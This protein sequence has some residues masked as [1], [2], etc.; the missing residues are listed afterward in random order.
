MPLFYPDRLQSNNPAS[1][2]IVPASEIA[3]FKSVAT[4]ASLYALADAILSESK[5]NAGNDAIGQQWYVVSK[6]KYYQLVS[7]ENRKSA[8]GWSE[9]PNSSDLSGQIEDVIDEIGQYSINGHNLSDSPIWIAGSDVSLSGYAEPSQNAGYPIASDNVNEGIGKLSRLVR[10]INSS[11]GAPDGI[12]T[13]DSAGKVPSSQLPSYVDDVIEYDTSSGFPSDGEGGKIYVDKSTNTTWRWSGTQY[14]Q[15]KGDL[16]IGTTSGTAFD[17]GV[18]TALKEDYE[19]FSNQIKNG[20]G[21]LIVSGARNPFS[22]EISND[23]GWEATYSYSNADNSGGEETLSI[24]IVNSS[25][26]GLMD[27]SM[28]ESHQDVVE[29]FNNGVIPDSIVVNSDSDSVTIELDGAGGTQNAISGNIPEATQSRAGVLSA[30]DKTLLDGIR[31]G[32]L[33]LVTPIITGTWTLYNNDDTI[34][35]SR[36]STDNL[37][38]EDGYKATFSGTYKWVSA[39]GYKN[40]T[41]V[42]S[43]SSWTD[44]PA[45]GVSSGT[46]DNSDTKVTS[47][48]TYRITIQAP[49]TGLMVDGD[50][51]VIASGNDQTSASRSITFRG[52]VYLGNVT[53]SSPT[54]SDIEALSNSLR[55]KGTW[56]VTKVITSP[57]QYYVIAYP[58]SYGDISTIIQD[59]ATPVLGAFN[60]KTV[61]RVN[62]AKKSVLMNVYTSNN[63][64]AFGGN[65]LSIQF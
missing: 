1:Y 37:I 53:S 3:G 52:R 65:S 16:V 30:E 47:N 45:D 12:A 29:G 25:S 33:P 11:I 58:Q 20:E 41:S 5:T 14:V 40:P 15:I 39:S 23:Y 54:A 8:S 36:P 32:N 61:T 34:A 7:W 46:N 51:V 62:A 50:D 63:P 56:T 10:G 38:V 42:A 17:G 48:T 35:S 27:S 21:A 19:N 9:V 43:G 55:S 2:G 44:L 28:Y 59:G 22:E 49:K 18:G 60:K 26:P 57:S 13:L 4:D 24:G 64:G 31:G 6:Q